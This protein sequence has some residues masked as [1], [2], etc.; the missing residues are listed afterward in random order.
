MTGLLFAYEA[1]D[2]GGRIAMRLPPGVVGDATFQGERQEYRPLLRRWIVTCA[3]DAEAFALFVGM[4][5]ST[6]GPEVNDPTICREWGFTTREGYNAMWKTNVMDF[7]ATKPADL[8]N[9]MRCPF[10]RSQGNLQTIR[11]AAANASLIIV[12]HGAL[13][14]NL[15]RYG[16]EAVEAL[17]RDGRTLWC[18]GLTKAGHP[19][20]PLYLHSGTPLQ[21]F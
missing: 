3:P 8:L 20:H 4:N 9:P 15:A 1:H 13:H 12:C 16:M 14:A 5:P 18:F 10:P 7:R 11:D 17:R 6:A 2:P 19:K 21:R